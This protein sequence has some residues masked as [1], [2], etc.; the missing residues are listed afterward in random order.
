MNTST[1]LKMKKN[2]VLLKVEEYIGALGQDGFK[3]GAQQIHKRLYIMG[4]V[5]QLEAENAGFPAIQQILRPLYERPMEK[6]D[7]QYSPGPLLPGEGRIIRYVKGHDIQFI[8]DDCVLAENYKMLLNGIGKDKLPRPLYEG[9][10][11]ALIDIR[12]SWTEIQKSVKKFV[13]EAQKYLD[14]AGRKLPTITDA[15]TVLRRVEKMLADHDF[16]LLKK[17]ELIDQDRENFAMHINPINR[18][19]PDMKGDPVSAL[20]KMCRDWPN[21]VSMEYAMELHELTQAGT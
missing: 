1:P 10:V 9:K 3:E 6:Y 8:A 21:I 12:G 17:Y 20:N 15:D 2:T 13:E 18:E 7:V 14:I 19:D 11:F 16:K 5:K 4:R